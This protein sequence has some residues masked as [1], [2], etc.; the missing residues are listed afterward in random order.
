M[1]VKLYL[2][3]LFWNTKSKK[4]YMCVNVSGTRENPIVKKNK[5][6]YPTLA[7]ECV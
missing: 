2:F 3:I 6:L 7:L 5:L 1:N 4:T